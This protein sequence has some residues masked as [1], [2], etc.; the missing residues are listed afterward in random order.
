[1][2]SQESSRPEH[3]RKGIGYAIAP[4][5]S[6]RYPSRDPLI[7]RVMRPLIAKVEGEV[8]K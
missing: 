7:T 5:E 4:T 8:N 3:M 1:M 2:P 6:S